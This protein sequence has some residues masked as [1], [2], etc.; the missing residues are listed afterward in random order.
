MQT[1]SGKGLIIIKSGW[2]HKHCAICF[3]TIGHGGESTVYYNQFDEWVCGE[4][5]INYIQRHDLSFIPEF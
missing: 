5:Y 2:D 1:D 3:A 4:C